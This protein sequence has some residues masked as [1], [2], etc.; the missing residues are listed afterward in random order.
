MTYKTITAEEAADYIQDGELVGIGGFSSV[1]V[2][3]EVPAALAKKAEA[4]HEKGIPFKIG[5]ITGGASGED[6]DGVL[7]RAHALSLRTPFQSN[8]DMRKA[9]N[10][11]EIRYFDLH[12]SK[13]A[14]E[15]R[16]GY[17]GYVD[18][19]IIEA[20]GFTDKGE[21]ILTTSVGITP[22]LAEHSRRLIIELNRAHD[23]DKLYSMHDL[24]EIPDPSLRE[25]IPIYKVWDR[26]GS[27]VLKIDWNKVIGVV[28][29]NR[30]DHVKFTPVDDITTRIGEN[31]GCF[32]LEE[33][34]RGLIPRSYLPI[35]SG[36]GNIA[37]AVLKSLEDAR[38]IPNFNMFT[39][40]I[41]DAVIDL[42]EKGRVTYAT[43]C[44]LTLSE[45]HLKKLY[46]HI[47]LF[48][49]KILLRPQ[50]ITNHPEVI[51]RLGVIAMNTAVEVDLYGHVNSTHA[52]GSKLINGIGGSGD[53]ARN[54]FISI[55]MC[56]ST[57]KGGLIS[58]IV[59]M[60][61]HVDSTEHDVSVIVTEQGVADL[62]GKD[63]KERAEAI[64]AHC[65]HPDYRP[66][67]RDYLKLAEKAPAHE[68]VSL[69]NAF[70]M[71]EAFLS[72]GD[73]KKVEFI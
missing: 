19:A 37:N 47:D 4:L 14:E 64:I 40:V 26:V 36:V 53:Y 35:Q 58:T 49:N 51:R 30:L 28:E 31:V 48:H 20:S 43:G 11:G 23:A 52:F 15:V 60:V 8:R 6:V 18:T 55:F 61:T 13:V 39:E 21:V 73:M 54:A 32:L 72:S 41:Q 42:M 44:S 56:P 65:A 69:I 1:G 10:N 25:P 7:T 22:T 5:L 59:P 2:P 45:S 38:E 70:K 66:F 3:K 17:A 24:F 12:L 68:P 29:T 27:K 46:D 16:Y 9:I 33:W 62:R 63:P 50:E 67:L 34:R 57:A 71:Q